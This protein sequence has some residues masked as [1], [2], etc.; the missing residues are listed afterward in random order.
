VR[1]QPEV[2]RLAVSAGLRVEGDRAAAAAEPVARAD[3]RS[4]SS[5][6]SSP[7]KKS[8]RPSSVASVAEQNRRKPSL[9][10]SA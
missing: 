6:D 2:P 1:Q 7:V 10:S 9:P 3:V 5:V 4:P 8:R